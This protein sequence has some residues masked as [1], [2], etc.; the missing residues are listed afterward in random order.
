MGDGITR[1]D[2][3]DGVAWSLIAGCAMPP[4]RAGA[5]D[6][7]AD[8]PGLTGMRGSR[9]ADFAAAHALRDGRT[10]RLEDYPVDEEVDC[11]V[12]GAG[13]GGLSS[14]YFVRRALPR[15]RVLILD[16]HDDFGGHAR[17][18]EFDVDGRQLIGYGGSESIQSPKSLWSPQALGLLTQL[19]VRLDR[20]EK[21]IDT[22][23]Y[24][25][26]GLSSGVF[27]ARE[28]YGRD[29][30]VAGDPQPSYPTDIPPALRQGRPIAEFA[31]A[32]PLSESQ[33][34]SLV[35][36]FTDRR[37]FL[38][39]RNRRQRIEL[40]SR[41]SYQ[42]FL[43]RYWR[44]EPDVVR[45]FAG[46]TYDWF[47][48][49]GFLVS[50]HGA[51]ENGYPGFQGLDLGTSQEELN[52]SQLYVHH[53]PDG[54]ASIARLLVRSLIPQAAA[55]SSMEDI[56]TAQF[57]YD[58]LDRAGRP[59][60]L[61]LSSTVVQMRNS[62]KGVDILYERGGDARRIRCRHAIW[63][64][65]YAMLPYV[66]KEVPSPQRDLMTK[67]L[68]VPMV[69]VNVAVR[70]WRPWARM[71]VHLVNNPNG[72]YGV[73]KLDYPVSLGSYRFARTPDEPMVLHLSHIPPPPPTSANRREAILA[74]RR[75]LYTR[76][77]GDFEAAL[78]DELARIL[79]PG[80]FDADRD[81]AAITV[82]RWGHGYAYEPNA[83]TDPDFTGSEPV[84]ARA[85]IG[86]I[87]LAGS[88]AAWSAYAH[89]AI[90]EA[91]RAAAEVA[92]RS[93]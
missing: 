22:A 49:P 81:I 77:F 17:R 76:P 67:A 28:K 65:Y 47:G 8:P 40:L 88:D 18:N 27:F 90:D 74:A 9:D 21:A 32:C 87:S 23:L 41:I 78:R 71:G 20:F 82:N 66:C 73:V 16:N 79:G 60:R 56:V 58:E 38:A 48:M 51:K 43:E 15:A 37:N 35:R 19:G 69:Y 59:V 31:A 14:A 25:G 3:I 54:N 5:Q 36:L 11:A 53:F 33:R 4:Q 72:F 64:G 44:L 52:E 80:G 34:Q 92:A 62:S 93:G 26:L 30:L 39:D 7:A 10:Y 61:R 29:A 50:A 70:H 84:R 68:R 1:R 6:T 42:D 12:V 85:P 55:G 46:R 91:H 83:L 89:A 63:A 24:P 75:Q 57:A 45:M 13:I 2:F 86:R